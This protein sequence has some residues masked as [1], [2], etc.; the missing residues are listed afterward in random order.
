MPNKKKIF[1]WTPSFRKCQPNITQQ[2]RTPCL[3]WLLGHA[4]FPEQG[5]N[6]ILGPR[7]TA[8]LENWAMS[9]A[10]LQILKAKPVLWAFPSLVLFLQFPKSVV[11]TSIYVFEKSL[12]TSKVFC[13]YPLMFCCNTCI[14]I[15]SCKAFTD[16][17]IFGLITK[18]KPRVF[19]PYYT[20]I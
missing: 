11:A 8:W 4:M 12:S 20:L 14:E 1:S 3:P 7:H 6:K 15:T 10:S 9:K 19:L 13:K 16:I 2:K 18:Q 17:H 5:Q